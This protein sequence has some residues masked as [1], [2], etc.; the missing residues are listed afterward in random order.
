MTLSRWVRDY[1]FFPLN[2]GFQEKK[3]RLYVTLV[4][5]MGVVGLWHGAGWGFVL[6]GLMHGVYLATYR[7]FE[8]WRGEELPQPLALRIAVRLITLGAIVAAWVP[9]RA[10]SLDQAMTM[11]GSMFGRFSFGFSYS[12]N[13]YLVA[14]FWCA[15]IALEPG[16][17]RLLARMGEPGKPGLLGAANLYVLRP[18]SY[19]FLLLLFLSFDNR[20]IQFIYFQF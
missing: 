19:A 2:A 7:A 18:V 11:L 3:V 10:A 5:I 8:N 6:W 15:W 14:L 9:F 13:F 17:A 12:V 4:A 20:D 1:V 16:L